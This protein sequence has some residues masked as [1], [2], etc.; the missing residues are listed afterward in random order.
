MKWFDAI[1]WIAKLL[2]RILYGRDGQEPVKDQEEF[3]EAT[4]EDNPS[5]TRKLLLDLMRR[6]N[7]SK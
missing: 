1:S 5:R 4:R 6:G 3:D 7:K 2:Y